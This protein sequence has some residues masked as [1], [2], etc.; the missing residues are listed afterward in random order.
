[1]AAFGGQTLRSDYSL[2]NE[3]KVKGKD[4]KQFSKTRNKIKR[5]KKSKRN[6][7]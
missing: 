3:E 4:K 5:K 7:N 6:P 1:M 2:S